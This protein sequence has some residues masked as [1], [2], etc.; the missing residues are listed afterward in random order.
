M[1][2][3]LELTSV[4]PESA[5]ALFTSDWFEGLRDCRFQ[6]TFVIQYF[7]VSVDFLCLSYEVLK[8]WFFFVSKVV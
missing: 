7:Q 8:E 6:Y 4:S 5:G 3:C 1:S 2:C